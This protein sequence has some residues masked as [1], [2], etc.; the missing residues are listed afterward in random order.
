MTY[1]RTLFDIH[2]DSLRFQYKELA[3][4]TKPAPFTEQNLSHKWPFH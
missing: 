1:I 2:A 3:T 4:R